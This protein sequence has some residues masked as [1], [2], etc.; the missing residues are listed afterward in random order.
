MSSDGENTR[1]PVAS[2]PPKRTDTVPTKLLP[3][4][5]TFVPPL[6]GPLPGAI[7]VIAGTGT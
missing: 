1:T 2:F 5:D 6:V 7:L 3:W 4:I